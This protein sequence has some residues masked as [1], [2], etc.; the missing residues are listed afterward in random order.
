MKRG[1]NEMLNKGYNLWH[2]LL[3][4]LSDCWQFICILFFVFSLVIMTGCSIA[5][6]DSGITYV[7]L[8]SLSGNGFP[9]GAKVRNSSNQTISTATV[10][11]INLNTEIW[12]TDNMHDNSTNN[13]RLTAN[14]AGIYLVIGEVSWESN[15]SGSRVLRIYLNGDK[16]IAD[17]IVESSK[18]LVT[19]Q[20]TSVIV[21]MKAN[22]YVEMKVYQDSGTNRTIIAY[23][24]RSPYFMIQ[25]IAEFIDGTEEYSEEAFM[26]G[27]EEE[28]KSSEP[29]S[30]GN[31]TGG[32]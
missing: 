4:F 28:A 3:S 9:E 1:I 7:D 20:I 6:P 15:A 5:E 2:R 29:I 23:D 25:K 12:D 30:S 19:A 14:T 27:G 31:E 21:S 16:M 24:Y 10:T 11:S 8:S 17:N 22:D 13:S 32:F 26:G 18:S